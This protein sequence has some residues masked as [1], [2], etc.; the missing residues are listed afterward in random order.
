MLLESAKEAR[1]RRFI[2]IS[3]DEI[4][5]KVDKDADLLEHSALVPTNPYAATKAAAEM[6][7]MAYSRGY[8]LPVIMVRSNNVYGPHQFPERGPTSKTIADPFQR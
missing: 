7:V 6:M 3:T 8:N 2:H 4:Y 1:I 5:G